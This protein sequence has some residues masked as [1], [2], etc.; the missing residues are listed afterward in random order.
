MPSFSVG[1]GVT[2]VAPKTVSNNDTGTIAAGGTLSAATAIVWAGGS[3]NPGVVIDNSGN[4]S[5]TTRGIDTSG[6]FTTGSFA[7]VNHA[8]ADLIATNN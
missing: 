4:I 8:D 7:L 2:D 6:S 3:T 5:A 1:N